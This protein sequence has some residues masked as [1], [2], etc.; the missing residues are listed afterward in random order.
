MVAGQR[1]HVGFGHAGL[2]VTVTAVGEY[3]DVHD[4]EVLLARVVN[5]TSKPIARFKVRK[6]EP[7]RVRAPAQ[8]V[9]LP[10]AA[11]DAQEKDELRIR[12]RPTR[13]RQR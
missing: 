3:F 6:P 9:S 12:D 8:H 5:K 10:T 2:T 7:T 1:I 13:R 4:G 11:D